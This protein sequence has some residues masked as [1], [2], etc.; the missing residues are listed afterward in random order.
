MACV[1][2]AG[3]RQVESLGYL[4]AKQLCTVQGIRERRVGAKRGTDAEG[5]G[6]ERSLAAARLNGIRLLP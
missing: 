6:D 3:A 5:G 2:W 1:G 4:L